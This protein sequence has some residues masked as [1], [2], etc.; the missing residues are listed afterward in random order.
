MSSL[1]SSLSTSPSTGARAGTASARLPYAPLLAL[2][3]SAFLVI[4]TEALPAGVLPEMARGLRVGQ[5]AMGQAL[6]LYALATCLSVIPLVR[7]TASWPRKRLLLTAVAD[8]R[9]VR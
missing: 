7:L 5:S 9:C 8:V 1:S 4:L 2:A 3:S 6:T